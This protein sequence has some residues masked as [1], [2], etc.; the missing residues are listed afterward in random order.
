M[1]YLCFPLSAEYCQDVS[2]K[3]AQIAKKTKWE[4]KFGTSEM[5]RE[6]LMFKWAFPRCILINLIWQIEGQ[7]GR[8]HPCLNDEFFFFFFHEGYF[9]LFI[10]FPF[11]LILVIPCHQAL[12]LFSGKLLGWR[13]E[14]ELSERVCT[15]REASSEMDFVVVAKTQLGINRLLNFEPRELSPVVC[16]APCSCF[17]FFFPFRVNWVSCRCLNQKIIP[18]SVL[19]FIWKLFV[20]K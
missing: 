16:P 20:L 4:S 5:L 2:L 19:T 1:H 11:N 17:F 13:V 18:N 7:T 8:W 3:L 14:R 10:F 9:G 6:L 15:L 12:L